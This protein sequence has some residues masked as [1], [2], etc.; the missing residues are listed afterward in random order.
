MNKTL[1]GT[2]LIIL[3][4][5]GFFLNI[6]PNDL[7]DKPART[8]MFAFIF[9]L[10]WYGKLCA[11]F[12][13]VYLVKPAWDASSSDSD[14]LP[15]DTA[16]IAAKDANASVEEKV[17]RKTKICTNCNTS[18]SEE[19]AF[20]ISCGEKYVEKT[21]TTNIECAECN[22]PIQEDQIFCSFCGTK[23]ES[24]PQVVRCAKCGSEKQENA[25]FCS[26]CGNDL[27]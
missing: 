7:I 27:T 21:I 4:I 24:K 1:A 13:G 3:S 20:C 6:T 23:N 8:Q 26:G 12:I 18:L 9:T 2:L 22:N 5:V 14:D 16:K 19:D 10:P 17:A 11:L 15:I 25:K